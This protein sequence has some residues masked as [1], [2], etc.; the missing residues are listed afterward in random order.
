MTGTSESKR[1]ISRRFRCL[2]PATTDPRKMAGPWTFA[3]CGL[4]AATLVRATL[5]PAAVLSLSPEVI[6]GKLTQKLKDHD[7]VD[8]LWRLPLLSTMREKPAGGNPIL[9]SLVTFLMKYIIWL[10]VTSA[11]ILQLQ[12]QPS[13]DGQELVVKVPLDMAAGFNMPLVK[14]I[15]EMHM[16]TEAQA[17]I[18]VETSERGGTLVLRNCSNSQGSLRLSLLRRF[19]FLVNSLADKVMSFLLPTL[20]TLV[21]SQL[22]PV[23]EAAFEDM[24]EDLLRLV[25]VPISLS[26]GHL[27]FDLL[28]PAIK[29][30]VIQLHLQAELSDSQGKVTKWFNESAV[31]LTMPTLEGEPFSLTIRQDV[32]NAAV[33]TLVPPEELMVLLDYV[34]PELALRLKSSIKVINEKE[35]SSEAQFYTKGDQLTLNLNEISANRIHLM[36]SGIGLFDPELLK[37]ITAEMLTSALLPNENGKLSSRIPVSMVKALGFEAASCSLTNDALVVTPASS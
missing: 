1:G 14:S 6:E 15:V 21:K 10:K 37:D 35:A 27:Q 25:R 19:S 26:S 18:R 29:H 30:D 31:S 23:I 32:V 9:G 33:A 12:I 16:E 5:S 36:N 7:A 13:A 17:I 2:P 28:S 11:N 8:I 24:R 4:L 34:L 20:P 3:L 22:C